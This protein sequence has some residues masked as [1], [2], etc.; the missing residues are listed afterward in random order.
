ME[1]HRAK[2]KYPHYRLE[3]P[4]TGLPVR[5]ERAGY[6][7]VKVRD[8]DTFPTLTDALIASAGAGVD[9]VRVDA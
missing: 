3:E 4:A 6:R 5:Q 8:A 7:V 9:A 1:T 2:K